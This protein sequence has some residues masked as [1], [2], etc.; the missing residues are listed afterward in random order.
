MVWKKAEH[1]K[2]SDNY[3]KAVNWSSWSRSKIPYSLPRPLP[4]PSLQEDDLSFS[5]RPD[6]SYN[7]VRPRPRLQEDD[8]KEEPKREEVPKQP[9]PEK[10]DYKEKVAGLVDA[11][12]N[13]GQNG[14][15]DK[16]DGV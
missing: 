8:Q 15:T 4:R 7:P 2:W 5:P 13:G 9:E 1:K 12:L 10:D 14:D 11:V 16:K 3:L 6:P